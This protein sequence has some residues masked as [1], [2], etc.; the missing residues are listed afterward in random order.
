MREPTVC[1]GPLRFLTLAMPS[2]PPCITYQI[3][4]SDSYSLNKHLFLLHP[5]SPPRHLSW[6]P[7]SGAMRVPASAAF[8]LLLCGSTQGKI[9]SKQ[10]KDQTAPTGARSLST[11]SLAPA[12]RV[13]MVASP[14]RLRAGKDEVTARRPSG[15]LGGTQGCGTDG[16][17]SRCGP[18]S[19]SHCAPPTSRTG[20][21]GS[22]SG[23]GPASPGS[24][25]EATRG[26]P[27]DREAEPRGG[28]GGGALPDS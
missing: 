8:H 28:A 16:A 25:A 5:R 12:C 22:P 19:P 9:K 21:P 23:S 11:L 14:G 26:G 7:F 27:D 18:R 1:V 24:R 6:S 4:K 20:P 13:G 2:P 3:L 17:G 15:Q 10:N